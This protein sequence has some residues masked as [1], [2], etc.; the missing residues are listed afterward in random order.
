MLNGNSLDSLFVL[1]HCKSKRISS[2][3]KTGGNHDWFD[4]KAGEN[5]TIAE[6]N[7]CGIIRHIWFT[8]WVGSQSGEEEF[9]LRK[10]VLRIYWDEETKPSVEV[11]LGDFFGIGFGIRK[12]YYSEAFAINP[13]DGR[14][15]NCFFAMPFRRKAKL[16]IQ[17]DCENNAS[18]YF[19]IDYEEYEK[20]PEEEIVYFH[21]CWNREKDTR[22][23]APLQPGYLDREKANVPGEPEW[24]PK[25]WL[26]KNTTG[27]DNYVILEAEGKGKFVGCN[28]NIDVFQ[29]QANEW[30]GEGDDMFFIDGE[31]W[32]PSLH[33]T[34]TEDYF[35][36]ACC[37][38]KEYSSLWSGLTVYSGEKAGFRFGGKNSMYRLHIK[39]PVYFEKSLKFSIEHGHANKLSNDYSSTA[40]WYQT[41]PHKA[42]PPLPE[43]SERLPRS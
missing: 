13:E 39:D 35:N 27:K 17:N 30:Y 1:N 2:Y 42:F 6:I 34:G 23:W 15:L 24:L 11:P 9:Y 12:C 19:Y 37:P 41:E 36:T 22:G 43:V 7:G 38:T 33:G 3:D 29:P 40:Y 25:A 21:A 16:Q 18:F 14:A 5:R 20:L 26:T 8:S 28:L 32:P 10:L 4:I 31:P